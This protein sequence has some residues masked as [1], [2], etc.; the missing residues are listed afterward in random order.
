MVPAYVRIFIEKVEAVVGGVST[1]E[2]V[3]TRLVPPLTAAEKKLL[4]L[5]VVYTNALMDEVLMEPPP[6]ATLIPRDVEFEVGV[7]PEKVICKDPPT[8]IGFLFTMLKVTAPK[9]LVK[10]GEKDILHDVR[11]SGC[12]LLI[13]LLTVVK[14][15]LLSEAKA[16]FTI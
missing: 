14:G 2:R 13:E 9:V 10:D 12:K 16:K 6:A 1:K 15:V 3:K 5:K 7:Y 8:G 4:S 11:S